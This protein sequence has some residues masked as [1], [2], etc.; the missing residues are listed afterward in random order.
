MNRYQVLCREVE[1]KA[2]RALEKR[3]DFEWLSEQLMSELHE[4]ISSSTLM[5]LWGY[6]KGVAP[7][8]STL[9]VLARYAGFA[10]YAE[11]CNSVADDG[12]AQVGQTV[13]GHEVGV[14]RNTSPGESG[15]SV[16]ACEATENGTNAGGEKAK[17]DSDSGKDG[18]ERGKD[19]DESGKDE[20]E[21]AKG[22]GRRAWVWAL[23][24]MAIA[25]S[26]VW[27]LWRSLSA[28]EV[29]PRGAEDFTCLL[30]N[31]RCDAD[32]L[33]AWTFMHGGWPAEPDGTLAYFMKD[34]DVCQVVHGLPAGEYELRARAWHLP[35][36]LD[37]A[38]YDYEHAEDKADGTALAQAEIY[39]GP[40]AQRVKNYASEFGQEDSC[41]ENVLRFVVL[42]DS[43][44]IGFRSDGN[45]PR[46]SRAQADDFRLYLI[47]RATAHDYKLMAAQLDS[48]RHADDERPRLKRGDR[49]PKMLDGVAVDLLYD[50]MENSDVTDC[51]RGREE[52]LP[53]GWTTQQEA[54][55]CRIVHRTD[56]GR[57]MG[58]SDIYLEYRSDST[59]SAG[60]LVGHEVALEAGT[61]YFA[62]IFFAQGAD[63][64]PTN[65]YFGAEGCA[66]TCPTDKLM[67]WKYFCV[68][69][70]KPQVL[71][72]GLWAPEGSDVQRAG[73]CGLKVWE[74]R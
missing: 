24:L 23:A 22:G 17:G 61:Y 50:Y 48:A 52:A 36:E 18:G 29:L 14:G 15:I 40:F 46:F 72:V 8:R 68:T 13:A 58:D 41:Y 54:R 19:G 60:L 10:D 27:W 47:R 71:T 38:L 1:R 4:M 20:G 30:R 45:W 53:E 35:C 21:R 49:I 67:D 11:F 39:A 28:R 44:R 74:R 16:E 63:G 3:S 69:V 73:I 55:R 56:A 59:A 37:K 9:D 26:G 62:A 57:G 2:G 6:R 12:E 51:W 66:D 65:V 70:S 42:D 31:A 32:S 43:V 7:R 33:G 5:R 64:M 34:F 25:C